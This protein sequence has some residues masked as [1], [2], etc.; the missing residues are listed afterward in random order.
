MPRQRLCL[1]ILSCVF[2]LGQVSCGDSIDV[3]REV[4]EFVQDINPYVQYS[5]PLPVPVTFVVDAH[6]ISVSSGT[7]FVT[8]I[9]V[10][11]IGA[12]KGLVG[13]PEKD[14][15]LVLRD[16]ASGRESAY[17]ITGGR[18]ADIVVEGKTHVAVTSTKVTIDVVAGQIIQVLP[19]EPP[20]YAG[21]P[22]IETS[23]LSIGVQA[24]VVWDW[25]N[26]RSAPEVPEEWGANVIGKYARGTLLNVVDGPACAHGGYWWR[27]AARDDK[28]G[29]MREEVSYARLLRQY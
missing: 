21:C 19:P 14:L 24:V 18:E 15:V 11:Q 8:P 1:I 23:T 6:G 16:R 29:W 17:R 27:V 13:F 28:V 25:V 3:P 7:A 10:F 20:L 5:P 4:K 22:P 26:M 12:A 2:V 9:G